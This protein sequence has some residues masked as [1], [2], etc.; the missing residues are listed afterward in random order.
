LA[1]FPGQ[2]LLRVRRAFRGDIPMSATYFASAAD[3]RRWLE[4]HHGTATELVVGFFKKSSGQGGLTY[5][6]AVD[7]L[8]CFGWID[9]VVRRIDDERYSHR[10]TPRRPRSIWS[11]VNVGHVRRLTRAGKMHPAGLAAFESH[12]SSRQRAYSFADRPQQFPAASERV[13]RSKKP[14]WTFW[15]DQP[16]GYQR[17]AI[18]WVTSA[19]QT[20]TRERRLAQLIALSA[21]GRRLGAK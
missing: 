1:A 13:F 17:A 5:T 3:F 11:K 14:A 6:E 16:P 12:V 4:K 10:V 2:A 15:R 7:E 21:V 8:L 18:H 20:A 19:R 9:G